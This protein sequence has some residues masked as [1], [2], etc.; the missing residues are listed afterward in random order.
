MRFVRRL[1]DDAACVHA[2]RDAV[3][4]R[5]QHTILDNDQFLLRVLVGLPRALADL[6]AA[7]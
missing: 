3:L 4:H 6:P 2:V 7:P 5:L 1:E